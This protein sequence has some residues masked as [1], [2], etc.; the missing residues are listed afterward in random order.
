MWIGF[1]PELIDTDVW[2][3][4]PNVS[5]AVDRVV[6][7]ALSTGLSLRETYQQVR[8]TLVAQGLQP[9]DVDMDRCI[10]DHVLMAI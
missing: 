10:K 5:L 3:S 7:D 6:R 2:P 8:C 4:A 1:N 9:D